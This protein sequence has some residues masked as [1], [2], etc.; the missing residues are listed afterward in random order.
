[1]YRAQIQVLLSEKADVTNMVPPRNQ[2]TLQIWTKGCKT[3]QMY[4]IVKKK[5]L[6]QR[7]NDLNSFTSLLSLKK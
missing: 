1:M 6:A 7:K 4:G 3:I 5:Q 2:K